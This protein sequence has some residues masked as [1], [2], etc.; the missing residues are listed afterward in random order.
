M[1][2]S[3]NEGVIIRDLSDL[4]V[5]IVLNAWWDSVNVDSKGPIAGNNCWHAPWWQFFLFCG[6]EENSRPWIICIVCHQFIHHP[7]Q[8]GPSSNGKHYL[9]KAY[10][11]KLNELTKSEIITITRSTVDDT[12]LAISMGLGRPGIKLVWSQRQFIFDIQFDPYWHKRKTTHSKLAAE[13]FETSEFH[14]EMW[15]C[16][17]RLGFALAH[18]AWNTIW[19]LELRRT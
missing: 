10:I 5:Q 7:S 9:T 14:Q 6:N 18:I 16:Y 15:N 8:H 12:P 2:C 17:L 1:V 19:N 13:D 3:K 11:A 4:T